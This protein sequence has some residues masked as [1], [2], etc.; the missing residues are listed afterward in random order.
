MMDVVFILVLFDWFFL[1]IDQH[2]DRSR[3][4]SGFVVHLILED[5]DIK[6]EPDFREY[7]EALIAVFELMLRTTSDMPRIETKLF[8]DWVRIKH[9]AG[10]STLL[11]SDSDVLKPP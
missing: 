4:T 7:E 3:K 8:V 6:F 1:S 5:T 2:S 10:S 9:L 11:E